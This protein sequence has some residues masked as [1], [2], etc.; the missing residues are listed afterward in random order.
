MCD[1]NG[2]VSEL[3]CRV[4][5]LGGWDWNA[6]QLVLRCAGETD[7][8]SSGGRSHLSRHFAA[9]N[10][11]CDRSWLQVRPDRRPRLNAGCAGR[12]EELLLY[13]PVV[14]CCGVDGK[15]KLLVFWVFCKEVR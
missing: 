8:K 9:E 1:A 5:G 7:R 4:F 14:F 3:V 11:S 10:N 12:F 6:A 13:S 2:R 15:A